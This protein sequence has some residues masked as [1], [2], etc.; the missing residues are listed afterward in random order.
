[1]SHAQLLVELQLQRIEERHGELV[2][3]L[4]L[5]LCTLRGTTLAVEAQRQG[6]KL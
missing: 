5:A 4:L 6:I 1:M 2:A 3:R